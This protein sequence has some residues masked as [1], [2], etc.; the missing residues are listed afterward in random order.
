MPNNIKKYGLTVLL[1]VTIFVGVRFLLYYIYGAPEEQA[2]KTNINTTA[3][4]LLQKADTSDPSDR[5]SQGGNLLKEESYAK[6]SYT[7]IIP[8]KFKVTA[9]KE[10]PLSEGEAFEPKVSPD[11]S[12]IVFIWKTDPKTILAI[13]DLHSNKVIAIDLGLA[14]YSHPSWSTDGTKVVFSANQDFVQ[15]IFT[16]QFETKK[17]I[18]VTNDPHRK[19]SWPS[20]SPYMFGEHYRIAYVSEEKGRKDIWWVR[21]NGESDMPL[22]IST[23]RINEYKNPEKWKEYGAQPPDLIT[24]GGDF[25][26]WSPSGNII[27]YKTIKGIY[28]GFVYNYYSWW[29]RAESLVLPQPEGILL[30][31][32]NQASF[33]EYNPSKNKF[34]LT[35]RGDILKKKRILH[36]KVLTS[37]P[38]FFPDGK[39]LVY[40]H[41]KDGRNFLSIEPLDDPLGDIANLWMYPYTESQK[42]R[43][44]KN[45]LLFLYAG[46]EQIYNVYES[47]FYYCGGPTDADEHARPYLVTSDAVLETFY[48]T[49]SALLSY[50]ER[51]EFANALTEFASKGLKTAQTKNVSKEVEN[52]FL[53]GLALI[54][55]DAIKDMPPEAKGEI[56]RI[57]KASG[58]ERSF[59]FPNKE[60][61]YADFL[62]RGKYERDK[63][64]QRYFQAL[65]WFQIFKFDLK[66]EPKNKEDRK[67]VV[68]ILEVVN[69]PEVY[70]QI[71]HINMTLKDI[72]GESRY[73]GP[74]SLKILS[75]DGQLPEIKSTLPWIQ[76]QDS[77]KLFPSIYTLDAFVFD[78][79]ITHTDRPETVGTMENPRLLPV[80]MD[81]MAAFGSNE[82]KKILLDE[83]KEGRFANYEKK[84]DDVNKT[85][86]QFSQ[87][88][89]S[90]NLY[91]V[92]LGLLN[93]II[94][95]PPADSPDF[96]HSKAWQRKQLNT[97]LGSWVNLRYAYVEQVAAE[98]GEGGYEPLNIGAPKGYVEPNPIFFKKLNQGFERIAAGFKVVIRDTQLLDAVI[99]RIEKYRSHLKNLETIAHK[100]LDN[101][102][103]TDDEYAEILYIGRTIEHFILIMNS[104]SPH[105]GEGGGLGIP[106][107][108]Q[109]IVDVQ[110]IPPIMGNLTLYEAL[111]PANEINVVVPFFWQKTDSEG[112][113]LFLL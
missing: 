8:I 22:T 63:D 89:W 62:I 46:Y 45:H 94:K 38:A 85:I 41:K 15:E 11:G 29:Q 37:A 61:S 21:E 35:S 98:C 107:P 60:I 24:E 112:I 49:F 16:Y 43:L 14:E 7:Q 74:L 79:L 9:Y 53:V 84:L 40:I 52:F 67:R 96:T 100:E 17:L 65:K 18:K 32:P 10:I 47:E 95:E 66:N 64:L 73:Y 23:D 28:S 20:F 56:A 93:N 3:E 105:E 68:E 13:I 90:Q 2:S 99:G 54:K 25:P 87:D 4:R 103:L 82:A 70:T 80:G 83:F 101:I 27:I 72:V 42:E 69:S 48:V 50:V 5:S 6:L 26:E 71:K 86:E 19:K 91:Q 44:A 113:C 75:T 108:I 88:V 51:V 92:W 78:E 111:G 77:F 57:Q 55:P 97:A 104:I 36:E 59:I 76:I 30:W 109:K 110:K 1:F 34:F 102:P 33:L 12:Q 106:D 39:G 31:S 81:I 58:F